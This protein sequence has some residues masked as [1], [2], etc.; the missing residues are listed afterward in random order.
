MRYESLLYSSDKV[1]RDKQT[2]SV[3]TFIMKASIHTNLIQITEVY[4]L[5][6]SF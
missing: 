1:L 6:K 3:V 2:T 5:F 4:S